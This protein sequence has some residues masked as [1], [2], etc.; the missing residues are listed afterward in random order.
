MLLIPV[1]G[2]DRSRSAV[3][4]YRAQPRDLG[5]DGVHADEHRPSLDSLLELLG[6][7][8]IDSGVRHGADIAVS[9]ALGADMAFIGRSYVYAVAA[10]GQRG[11]EHV[12]AMLTD[13][14]RSVMQLSGV[15]TLSELRKHGAE[16]LSDP[17]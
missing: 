12:I 2:L 16:L 10:A 6:A 13:Q 1:R 7:I 14:L 5:F 9:I 8:V 17:G 3:H 15:T 11:V 4:E